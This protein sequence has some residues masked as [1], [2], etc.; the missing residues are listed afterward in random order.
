M[1]RDNVVAMLS[2][3]PAYVFSLEARDT[4]SVAVDIHTA[5]SGIPS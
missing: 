4:A 1:S 5:T 3:R 2:K